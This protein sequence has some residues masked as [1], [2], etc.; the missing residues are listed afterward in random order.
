MLYNVKVNGKQY[1]VEVEKAGAVQVQQPVFQQ[2]VQQVQ[3]FAQ[4]APVAQ[5]VQAA[6]APVAAPASAET[7]VESPM[8]GS[9]WEIKVSVGQQVAAGE[10][11][12][13]LEAM[14]MENEVVA[15]CAGTVKQILVSKGTAVDTDD[16]LVVLN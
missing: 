8:P 3:Q 13:V 14:K 12:V 5:P 9:V 15:P 11:L 4:P 6:P 16:V 10:C 2:P 7:V 1:V